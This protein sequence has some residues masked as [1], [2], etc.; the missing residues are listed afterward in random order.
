MFSKACE[1][2]IRATVFIA[3][4][5]MKGN[6][7]NL[8]EI[9]DAITSPV[10]FTAKI[11]QNLVK[12]NIIFSTKGA[13]GGFEMLSQ[14]IDSLSLKQ[15]V[16]AIDGDDSTTG[17][18]V[19]LNMCS[20]DNPCPLHDKYVSIRTDLSNM[21]EE[22]KIIQLIEKQSFKIGNHIF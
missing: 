1:Y 12:H 2:A 7:S 11:L 20:A 3:K 9:S 15:L 19:G 14:T 13:S 21:L 22:T 17:C 18:I 8:R 5:S 6:R 4:E 16:N 10:A